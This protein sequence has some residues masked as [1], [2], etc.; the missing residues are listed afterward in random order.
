MPTPRPLPRRLGALAGI[1]AP[2]C[3]VGGW[4]LAGARAHDYDPL[5]D[6]IS[7][8]ARVGAPT[9]PLMTAG[10]VGFGV[11]APLWSRTLAAA[12]EE[13][14]L[15]T[16]VTA[17]GLGTLAV[18]ALPLGASWGDA[19][20]A[21]AAGV[22]YVAMATSPRLGGRALARRGRRR[23]ART[24]YATGAASAVMLTASMLGGYDGAL[25]RAGLGVVDAWFVVLAV[26][27]LRHHGDR[28]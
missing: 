21:A 7:D 10:F 3:F 15:R 26:R 12:L 2:V 11:L 22:S 14:G 4:L 5:R 27:E 28:A 9:R 25:Q 6:F 16:T 19:P 1:G 23:A 20:H 17:A 18:A 24:S 8:L 13:P